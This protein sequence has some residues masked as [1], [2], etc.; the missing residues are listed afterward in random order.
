MAQITKPVM[1]VQ[2]LD[3]LQVEAAAEAA[4]QVVGDRLEQ[5]PLVLF[6]F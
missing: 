3:M 1:V 5:E 6:M 2:Q 4:V